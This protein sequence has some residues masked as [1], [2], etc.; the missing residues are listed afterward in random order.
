MQG[1]EG[2]QDMRIVGIK[3]RVDDTAAIPP[4]LLERVRTDHPDLLSK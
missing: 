3:C 1:Q 2:V 4:W